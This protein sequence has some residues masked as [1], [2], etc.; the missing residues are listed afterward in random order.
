MRLERLPLSSTQGL[1]KSNPS[2]FRP[3]CVVVGENDAPAFIPVNDVGKPRDL[4]HQPKITIGR[5]LRINGSI[6]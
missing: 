5:L 6:R 4:G 2:D 3:T 1:S